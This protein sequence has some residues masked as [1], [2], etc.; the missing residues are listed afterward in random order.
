MNIPARRNVTHFVGEIGFDQTQ[1]CRIETVPGL[2]L[3]RLSS[4]MTCGCDWAAVPFVFLAPRIIRL[5]RR[6]GRA[7]FRDQLQGKLEIQPA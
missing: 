3:H 4:R 2:D 5:R 1:E 7:F 6:A